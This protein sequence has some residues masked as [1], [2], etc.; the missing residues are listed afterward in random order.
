MKYK[1]VIFDF[2]GTLVDSFPFFLSTVNDLA[3]THQ[4]KKVDFAEI[5]TLRGY[6]AR[7]LINH[8]G[9]PLWKVPFVGR[10]F[11]ARMAEKS[12]QISLFAGIENMLQ[13]LSKNGMILSLITS[14]SYSNVRRKLNAKSMDL[15][16]YPQ[17]SVS[18][19]GKRSKLKTILRKTGI[20]SSQAIFVGDEF[21]DLEAAKA[22]GV[23]FGAVAWGYTR[24]DALAEHAPAEIFSCVDEMA[25]KLTQ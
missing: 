3:E 11:K 16:V 9:L 25:E 18:L 1:L 19:F 17:C 15:M 10:D 6:D 22:E 12:D 7:R 20:D 2:D 8:M 23:A 13:V 4:F 14:N 24:I 5:E 21:R